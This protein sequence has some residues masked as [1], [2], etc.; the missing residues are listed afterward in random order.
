MWLF[1]RTIVPSIYR[2]RV[3]EYLDSYR[4]YLSELQ[5]QTVAKIPVYHTEFL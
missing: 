4:Y 1:P 3:S 5:E 2:R